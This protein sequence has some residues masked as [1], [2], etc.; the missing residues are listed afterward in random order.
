MAKG[1]GLRR[2]WTDLTA[3]K[4]MWP[5]TGRLSQYGAHSGARRP[6]RMQRGE[7]ARA[8]QWSSNSRTT[9]QHGLLQ[10]AGILRSD[11]KTG[12]ASVADMIIIEV[13]MGLSPARGEDEG[14][15]AR[16]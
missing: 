2:S 5:Q 14:L 11:E 16:D 3:T 13:T 15:G 4:A 12:Q 6:V 7:N 9:R 10:L 8:Q 1:Y